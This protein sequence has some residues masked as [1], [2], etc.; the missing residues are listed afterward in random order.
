[1]KAM[2]E[3]ENPAALRAQL[4]RQAG[5]LLR[6]QTELQE[7]QQALLQAQRGESELKASLLGTLTH[8][9]KSPMVSLTGYLEL[10]RRGQA[11]PLTPAQEKLLLTAERNLDRLHRT[12]SRL[13]EY[14][15]FE[16]G[17]VELEALPLD[18]AVWG[19][20]FAQRHAA[21]FLGESLTLDYQPP[22]AKLPAQVDARLLGLALECLLEN[23]AKFSPPGGRILLR[24]SREAEQA[25]F[26]LRDE[27]SGIPRDALTR[28]FEGFYQV[29]RSLARVAG[30]LGIGLALARHI[31]LLH[32]GRLDIESAPG[33]G[34]EVRLRLPCAGD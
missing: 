34:T 31:A 32:G 5:A 11:G 22:A 27:G 14:S 30:G 20:T 9:L 18:L 25:V 17:Q 28:V 21:L 12:I 26:S 15:Q 29:D 1:M 13:V 24:L 33:A 16:Q 19:A 3:T 10:L 6:L 7:S 8:E 2:S 23:S 4:A